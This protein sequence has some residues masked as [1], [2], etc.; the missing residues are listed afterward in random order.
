M[1]WWG[2]AMEIIAIYCSF[3]SN[4]DNRNIVNAYVLSEENTSIAL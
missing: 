3:R 2:R 1:E 4:K